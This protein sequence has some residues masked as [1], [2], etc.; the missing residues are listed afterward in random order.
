M[1]NSFLDKVEDNATVR[2]WS[3]KLQLEKG[4]SLVEGYT[5]ELWDFT[6][7]N[8]TQNELQ[9]LR[10]IWT[11]WEYETKQMF[12]HSYGDISY[13]LDVRIDKH[14]FRAMV[15]FWNSAYSCFSFGKVDLVPTIEEYTTLLRSPKEQVDKVYIR[16]AYVPPFAKKLMKITGMSEQWISARIQQKG[17]GRYIP[18]INLRDLI[19]T[20]PDVRRKVDTFALSIYGLVIFPK[21]LRNIDEAI[22]DLFDR[23]GE[24]RFIGCAQLLTVW[25]H[26][27]FWK[28]DKVSY[29]PFCDVWSTEEPL[30]VVPTELEIVREDFTKQ[31]LELG[32]KIEQLEEE[33]MHLKWDV[34]AQKAEAEELKKRKCKTEEDLNSLKNDYKKM[35]LSMK[36][37]GL[38]KTSGSNTGANGQGQVRHDEQDDGVREKLDG[39]NDSNDPTTEW[40]YGERKG[41]HREEAR[42]ESSRQLEDRCKWLEEEF[43]TLKNASHCPGINA[44]DLSL[45]PDLVLPNK[46]KMPEFEKYNGTSCPEAH[47]TMF[48]RRMAGY[49][50]NDQLLIHCFQDSLIG[51][52]A[53]WYNQLSHTQIG[54]WEDL[55]QAFIKQYGHVTD[56]APDRF[57]LQNIE[58]KSSES[59]K[60][61]AQR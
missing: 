39:S 44:K 21:A 52:T 19:L 26:A 13:L 42:A 7:I 25:F 57:M 32:K 59:F 61:Y 38:G 6:R 55:A 46:F 50:H 12:Y 33:K 60:Q 37:A 51:S 36:T 15:Q 27:H 17:E 5:S 9:E 34:E 54:S 49:V 1:E 24:G 29:R 8:V 11:H 18:W 28:M 47:I 2:V 14:M 56:V 22:V 45:V 3:E 40:T 35:R 10:D 23:A 31:S 4:D 41:P 48:C 53:K 30:R 43:K 58:K 20:H 16:P